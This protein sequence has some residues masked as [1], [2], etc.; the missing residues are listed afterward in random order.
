M[1]VRSEQGTGCRLSIAT[2]AIAHV[3]DE[4][5]STFLSKF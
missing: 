5:V 4:A 3:F 2:D 1:M